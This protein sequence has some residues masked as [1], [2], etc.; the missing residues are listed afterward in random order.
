VTRTWDRRAFFG[1]AAGAATTVVLG[2]CSG[3]SS[4]QQLVL[5]PND[6]DFFAGMPYRLAFFV[7]DNANNAAP[8]ALDSPL[9]VRI[10]PQGGPLGP[11]MATTIHSDGPE[12]NYALTSYTF[13]T[14]GNY[15]VEAS[16]KGKKLTLP[17]SV[18]P[19]NASATPTIG[20]RMIPVATPTTAN[21]EGVNPIC[22]AQP[23]CPFHA[24]SLDAALAAHQ[25]VA[26]Q[27]ATPA[28]CQ[29]KFCGPV[30]SN[31]VA[32]S[33]PWRD[34][35]TFIHAEIYTDLSGQTGTKAVQAWGL[36]HEPMLY[37]GNAAGTIVARVDNLYD[38]VEARAVLTAA[39]GPAS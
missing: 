24:V 7:A 34:R 31:L 37:L 4:K 22:T 21:H 14:P 38:Q 23:P 20:Q 10:G 27:F 12:P 29:S 18:T 3:G 17:L 25:P 33:G 32:V 39:Y 11:S 2:A 1:L 30:L 16:F 9:T 19:P 28:L 6:W 8:V 5:L 26:L 35:V 15:Q 13:T 36:Q